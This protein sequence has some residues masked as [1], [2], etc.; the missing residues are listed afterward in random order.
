MTAQA[1]LLQAAR[2]CML[3]AGIDKLHTLI[4]KI[5]IRYNAAFLIYAGSLG[6]P[7]HNS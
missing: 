1:G 5:K 7:P 2:L 4:V 6:L 3:G